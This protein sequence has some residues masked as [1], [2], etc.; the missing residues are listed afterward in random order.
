MLQ[1]LHL[2]APLPAPLVCRASSGA[3]LPHQSCPADFNFLFLQL[4]CPAAQLMQ[5]DVV[6]LDPAAG[7]DSITVILLSRSSSMPILQAQLRM[8]LSELDDE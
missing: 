5:L 7:S 4:E 6:C 8:P 3:H 2:V 1:K